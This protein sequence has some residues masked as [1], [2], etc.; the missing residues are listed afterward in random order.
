MSCP[1]S[2]FMSSV[3]PFKKTAKGQLGVKTPEVLEEAYITKMI[4]LMLLFFK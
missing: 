1:A 3:Q 4:D 2:H